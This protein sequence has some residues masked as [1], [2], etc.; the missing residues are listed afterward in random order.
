MRPTLLLTPSSPSPPLFS[1]HANAATVSSQIIE[2]SQLGT[3][4]DHALRAGER[5]FSVTGSLATVCA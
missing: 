5:A 2:D 1:I 3:Q 4:T